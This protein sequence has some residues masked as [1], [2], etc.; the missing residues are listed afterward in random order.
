MNS[1]P[2]TQP[3]YFTETILRS[4]LARA[5]PFLTGRM[6]DAGCGGQRYK[7]LFE[8]KEYIG[9]DMNA[10][11]SPNVVGDLRDMPFEAGEFDSI[12]NNQVLEH[13]DDTHAVF[14]EF[15][16]VL[17]SGGHLCIT[18]PFIG[19]THGVPHDYW[20]FSEYGLRFLFQRYGFDEV[21]IENMGGFLT[22]QA[23][24]W[25]FW[26]WERLSRSR[27][28]RSVRLPLMLWGNCVCLIIYKIDH[29][30]TTPFNYLAIGKKQ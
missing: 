25:M 11:L 1:F 24:L 23:Y 18:V 10:T 6:L 26:A 14:S 3:W 9:L 5:R 27:W 17:R 13:V 30:R 4:Y 8:F 16:R 28:Q 7:D 29:D 15:R 20:R 22:T 21:I 12:L 2:K 19:R